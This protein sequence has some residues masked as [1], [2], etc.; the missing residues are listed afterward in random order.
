MARKE[1][2]NLRMLPVSDETLINAV[3]YSRWVRSEAEDA[4]AYVRRRKTIDLA[5][6][7][8]Q[9]IEEELTDAQKQIIRLRYY[10]ERTPTQIAEQLGIGVSTVCKTLDRAEAHIRRSLRYVIQYQHDMRNME[11]LP[12]A[13]REAMATAAGRYGRGKDVADRLRKLRK[14]EAKVKDLEKKLAGK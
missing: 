4:D 12:C 9:V 10:E 2:R 13:L 14:S 6:L 5:Q 7:V 3:A 1:T 11:V 8:Q